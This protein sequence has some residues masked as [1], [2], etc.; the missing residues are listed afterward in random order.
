M[1]KENVLLVLWIIYGFIFITA[2]DSI[3]YFIIHL[4]YF[5]SVLSGLSFTLMSIFLPIITLLL[6]VST[7]IY[8][9][10]NVSIKSKNRGIYFT[11]FPIKWAIILGIISFTLAPITNKLSGLFSEKYIS[12]VE[13]EMIDFYSFYGWFNVG[14]GVSQVLVIISLF[15]FF[16]IKLKTTDFN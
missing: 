15:I 6:Y 16:M 5:A 7:T 13:M 14:L 3:L 10:R 12:N 8:L 2:V 9:L 1:K 4:I 11:H